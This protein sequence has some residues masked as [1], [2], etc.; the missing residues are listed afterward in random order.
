MKKILIWVVF[1]AAIGVVLFSFRCKKPNRID[2]N[3]QSAKDGNLSESIPTPSEKQEAGR[4]IEVYLPTTGVKT[5]GVSFE[6]LFFL[7]FDKWIELI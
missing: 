2:Q 7:S 5:A 6:R 3:G 1:V 4:E